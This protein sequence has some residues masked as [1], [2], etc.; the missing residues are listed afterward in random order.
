MCAL[1]V[2][3]RRGVL[4]E[5]VI[6]KLS[7]SLS[8]FL[9]GVFLRDL[10]YLDEAHADRNLDGSMNMLKFLFIGDLILMLQSYQ[11]RYVCSGKQQSSVRM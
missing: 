2:K 5:W 7:V 9:S 1:Y 3:Q 6:A 8:L 10:L 11:I 4:H